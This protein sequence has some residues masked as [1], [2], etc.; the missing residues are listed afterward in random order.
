MVVLKFG[1]S[2]V[3]NPEA[4]KKVASIVKEHASHGKII[5]VVSAFGGV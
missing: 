3:K 1:G 4:L 2:S 5:V